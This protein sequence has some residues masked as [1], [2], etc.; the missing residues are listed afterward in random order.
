M[1]SSGTA[2]KT[3]KH[4]QGTP[5]VNAVIFTFP[6]KAFYSNTVLQEMNRLPDGLQAMPSTQLVTSWYQQSFEEVIDF[7]QDNANCR[8]LVE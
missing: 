3:G 8:D 7:D 6:E 1:A 2:H 4:G 5:V